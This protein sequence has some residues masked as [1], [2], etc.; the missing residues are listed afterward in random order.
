MQAGP[1]VTWLCFWYVWTMITK[2]PPVVF[3]EAV[4]AYLDGST[5]L[6]TIISTFATLFPAPST[7][8]WINGKLRWNYYYGT[9]YPNCRRVLSHRLNLSVGLT[10]SRIHWVAWSS[11][12]TITHCQTLW[13]VGWLYPSSRY[14]RETQE[15]HWGRAASE[16]DKQMVSWIPHTQVVL[17]IRTM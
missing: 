4:S 17:N 8:S 11:I 9:N 16:V 13:Q 10:A 2:F 1:L 12:V 3:G 7:Q 14:Q 15:K 6:S 5:A